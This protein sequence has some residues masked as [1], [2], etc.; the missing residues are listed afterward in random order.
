MMKWSIFAIKKK[1]KPI[2]IKNN[3]VLCYS[4][5]SLFW[6]D[7][8][9]KNR[10]KICDFPI[11]TITKL[12]S[13]I[14]RKAERF[15]RADQINGISAGS[16]IYLSYRSQIFLLD[17]KRN[18]IS[19]DFHIPK[20]RRALSLS[21]ANISNDNISILFGEYFSNGEKKSVHIWEKDLS[22]NTWKPLAT[23]PNGCINH[24]HSISQIDN[25]LYVLTGDF[26]ESPGIW[27][28]DLKS[29]KL[30]P[31]LTG[32]QEYRSCWL[33]KLNGR[34]YFATD[35]QIE[36]NHLQEILD[37]GSS[38]KN[39]ALFPIEGSSIYSTQSNNS[40]FFSTTVEGGLPTG[41]LIIDA[42]NKKRGPG[43]KSTYA[44]IYEILDDGSCNEIFSAEKD[45]MPFYL[46]QFGTFTFPSG[47]INNG[48]LIAYCIGLKEFDG[49]TIVLKK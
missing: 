19:I 31:L 43:I 33:K 10:E 37:L 49:C 42:F 44:K 32:R 3:L 8:D 24:I 29:K 34:T 11:N 2:L 6:Y 15:F 7:L 9:F 22:K 5:G 12:L 45:F 30:H 16:D 36:N 25:Q 21:T 39:N 35:S 20:K 46:G 1:V 47:M 38:A 41:N 27:R 26:E 48:S 14:S 13:R 4:K 18:K 40:I 28:I 17:T 23:F